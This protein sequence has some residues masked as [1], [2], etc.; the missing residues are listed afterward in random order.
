MTW[1]TSPLPP[2]RF[3]QTTLSGCIPLGNQGPYLHT[4]LTSGSEVLLKTDITNRFLGEYD[5]RD[6]D[7]FVPESKTNCGETVENLQKQIE[8]GMLAASLMAATRSKC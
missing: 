4:G 6:L 3:P 1:A 2:T 8:S 7:R 5:L